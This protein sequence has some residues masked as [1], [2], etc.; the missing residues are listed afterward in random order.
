MIRLLPTLLAAALL[1][2][3]SALASLTGPLAGEDFDV[4]TAEAQL[5]K[6]GRE[7]AAG[8]TEL[9]LDRLIEVSDVRGLPT[10]VRHR[11]ELLIER[12]AYQR[13]AE[14]DE[15][16]AP[17]DAYESLYE[18][19]LPGRASVSAGVAA[20]RRKLDEDSPLS[21]YRMIRRVDRA[22]PTHHERVAAGDVV[23][24]AGLS[25]AHRDDRY[26]LFFRYRSRAAEV[27][28]YLV[29]N[30]PSNDRCEVA[31]VTLAALYEE[32][33]A[34]ETAQERH[35]DLLLYHAQGENAVESELR[36]PELRLAKLQRVDFDRREMLLAEQ[37]LETWLERHAGHPLEPRALEALERTR[38]SLVENDLAIA[39]FYRRIDS[40]FGA[41][42][43]AE[44]AA[45]QAQ[46]L[47]PGSD[48][49]ERARAFS[50]ALAAAAP[51]PGAAP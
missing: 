8:D 16:G 21:A 32:K 31:Y 17:S 34:L 42:M 28:E 4:D 12:A 11:T 39:E 3:C 7:L 23:A 43:H 41:R 30:Y 44:R 6:A 45:V 26:R 50:E 22:H 27:L 5:E 35:E 1:A 13:L 2:G 40:D 49:A 14:L 9:A 20:A 51:Q 19:E 36:I 37:E 46:E 38:R 48:L 29:L 18:R 33:G 47:A 15:S 25:M 10:V 24:D